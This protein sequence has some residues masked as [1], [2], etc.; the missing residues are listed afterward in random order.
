MRKGRVYG[1]VLVDV[2]T[3]RPV[4]LLPDREAGTVADWLADHPG[5]EV[6][7]RD[8]GPFFAEGSSIGAHRGPGRRPVPPLVQPRRC[9]RA[10]HDRHYRP[11]CRQGRQY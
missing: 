7:C 6:V 3:C 10:R 4:D 5:I 11:S 9:G 1:T 8:R 2:E